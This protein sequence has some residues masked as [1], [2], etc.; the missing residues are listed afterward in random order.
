M[1]LFLI[2]VYVIMITWIVVLGW[3]SSKDVLVFKKQV[4]K[5]DEKFDKLS[6]PFNYQSMFTRVLING[7]VW[8]FSSFILCGM[9]LKVI[10]EYKTGII[11]PFAIVIYLYANTV[12]SVVLFDFKTGVFWLGVRFKQT[13]KLLSS[14]F[15]KDHRIEQDIDSISK[16]TQNHQFEYFSSRSKIFPENRVS[17]FKYK[18]RSTKMMFQQIRLL[19]LELCCTAKLLSKVYDMQLLLYAVLLLMHLAASLY[20]MYIDIHNSVNS[21]KLK[22]NL[23]TVVTVDRVVNFI[24]LCVVSYDCEHTMK[25]AS[26]MV[27]VVHEFSLYETDVELNEECVTLVATYLVIV[28]Q[29]S[30]DT[31]T[32][33][34]SVT[35][36]STIH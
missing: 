11:V 13:S 34:D 26:K 4:S 16:S 12:G 23:I 17:D 8:L 2:V 7:T 21:F 30:L 19:H 33:D 20:Y 25:Q 27:K 18:P 29:F 28:I 15:M 1:H 5:V 14:I 3:C 32:V 31:D 36:N 35:Q 10:L 9:Y 22:F 6:S 24:K